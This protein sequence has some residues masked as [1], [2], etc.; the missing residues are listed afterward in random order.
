MDIVAVLT[1]KQAQSLH[2]SSSAITLQAASHLCSSNDAGKGPLSAAPF[3]SDRSEFTERKLEP[4]RRLCC[5][6]SDKS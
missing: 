5:K 3:T 6:P 2:C 4:V 1:V